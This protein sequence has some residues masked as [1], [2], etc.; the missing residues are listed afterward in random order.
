MFGVIMKTSLTASN[1]LSY[2][3]TQKSLNCNR[4]ESVLSLILE[5]C[6]R[7]GLEEEEVGEIISRDSTLLS[8]IKNDCIKFKF[9]KSEKISEEW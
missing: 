4:D 3:E 1:I 6:E 9:M 8:I 2:L 7:N 5:Y